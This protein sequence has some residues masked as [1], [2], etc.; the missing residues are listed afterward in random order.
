MVTQTLEAMA[1]GGIYDHIGGGF[2]RYSTDE[3]W[4]VPHFEKM[5]YDNALLAKAYLEGFQATGN[6]VLARI[7]RE[8]LDYVLR[9]MT[10]PEGGFYS[11][12]DA[13]SEGEEGKFFVWTP[14][15]IEAVLG[16]EE[17]AW[18]CAAYDISDEG[19][20]EGKSVPNMPR[21]LPRVASR[22]SIGLDQ[23]THSIEAGRARL[24]EARRR[25]V[26]PGLDDK[27][28]TAWNGMMVGALAEGYRVLGDPRYLA[29]ASRAADFLLATLTRP[30]GGLY[31]TYRGG[32]AHLPGYLEDYA[33]LAEG[34]LD[35]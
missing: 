13:D 20:W 34:L 16:P 26:P 5:L 33:F 2:A 9:E 17:G 4:L 21:P 12:T 29:G 25:R 1:R 24:Y 10:G 31:R 11:S 28:L 15:E 14:R 18:F 8:T 35:L 22:L 27:V 32:K 19:N 23:L 6:P 3:R 30:D 7:A